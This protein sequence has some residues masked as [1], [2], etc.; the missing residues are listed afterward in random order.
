M[1]VSF[2]IGMPPSFAQKFD[3]KFSIAQKKKKAN[4]C[5]E[6]SRKNAKIIANPRHTRCRDRKAG[7][8][9]APKRPVFRSGC[10][11]VGLHCGRIAAAP[12]GGLLLA[13]L[14]G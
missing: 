9:T 12:A 3:V 14:W 5:L 4:I 8:G 11:G 7:K 13:D 1:G 6:I 10:R 2:F